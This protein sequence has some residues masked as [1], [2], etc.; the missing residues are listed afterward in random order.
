MLYIGKGGAIVRQH[1]QPTYA[2]L[3]DELGGPSSEAWHEH[4]DA[5]INDLSIEKASD[6]ARIAMTGGDVAHQMA[7]SRSKIDSEVCAI[8]HIYSL[9]SYRLSEL[10]YDVQGQML[11]QIGVH[12]VYLM[13]SDL[14]S[15]TAA[16]GQNSINFNSEELRGWV[17]R[18]WNSRD[19]PEMKKPLASLYTYVLERKGAAED[20]VKFRT[21]QDATTR[22][23]ETKDQYTLWKAVSA[24]LLRM[25]RM[26]PF[27]VTLLE[28]LMNLC[29]VSGLLQL[30]YKTMPWS[31]ILQKMRSSRIRCICWPDVEGMPLLG[32]FVSDDLKTHHW[33]L[34]YDAIRSTDVFKTLRFERIGDHGMLYHYDIL[35]FDY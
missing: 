3:R 28:F 26:Y 22:A 30:D 9:I 17:D 18:E 19:A 8:L 20:L 25:L 6:T 33:R 1:L 10:T 35:R 12:L 27:K 5:L 32:T 7:L 2:K 15:S 14:A 4:R 31:S 13:V 23:K 16:H 29:L 34:L 11:R 24:D 21:D